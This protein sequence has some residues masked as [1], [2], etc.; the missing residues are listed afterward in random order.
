MS[1]QSDFEKYRPPI[2]EMTVLKVGKSYGSGDDILSL[3]GQDAALDA[4]ILLLATDNRTLGPFLLKSSV[5]SRA[6][7][8]SRRR[9][10]WAFNNIASSIGPKH[11]FSSA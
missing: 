10:F 2:T 8:P 3:N 5:R 7:C 1:E 6:L 9:R 11:R 4:F